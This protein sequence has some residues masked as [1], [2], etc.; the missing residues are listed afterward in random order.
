MRLFE[1]TPFDRPPHCDVCEQPETD[2]SCPPPEEPTVDGLRLNVRRTAKIAVE[3]RKRGKV[4]TTVRG[5]PADENDLAGLLGRLK[6]ACGAGG[7]LDGDVLEVQ[8]NQ[9][10]RVKTVL[11][12]LGF[13]VAVRT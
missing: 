3:K 8:G 7:G 10:D 1:G 2:C 5:L 13:R 12:G 6:A 9:R 4:V 11:A